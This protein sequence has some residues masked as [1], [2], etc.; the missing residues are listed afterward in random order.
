MMVTQLTVWLGLTEARIKLFRDSAWNEQQAAT[1][2][3]EIL[4]M[5]AC[6]EETEGETEIKH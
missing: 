4:R 5:L 1:N 3:Q 2:G 6:C